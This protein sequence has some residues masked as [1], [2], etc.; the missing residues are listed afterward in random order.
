M[1][2]IKR[3]EGRGALPYFPEL[4]KRKPSYKI[5]DFGSLIEKGTN[6]ILSKQYGGLDKTL[7]AIM[8]VTSR[9]LTQVTK[10]ANHLITS[11]LEQDCYHV[12]HFLKTQAN[13]K[14]DTKGFEEI[15]TPARSWIDRVTGIDCEDYSIF[16]A[17]LLINMGYKPEY[18]IV[19][20]NNKPNF[21]HI[22]LRCGQ[23]IIDPVVGEFHKHPPNVTKTKVIPIIP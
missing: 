19:A 18:L 13:Y 16:A 22:Y 15:R 8:N 3:F 2:N 1:N 4:D 17:C 20:F 14:L 10:L 5:V 21:G 9:G 12:W 6:T 23:W 7:L 11:N